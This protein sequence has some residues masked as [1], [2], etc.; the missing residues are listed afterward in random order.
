MLS[1]FLTASS[2][3]VGGR[4]IGLPCLPAGFGFGFVRLVIKRRTLVFIKTK[5]NQLINSE[6]IVYA[7]YIGGT[8]MKHSLTLTLTKGE[9]AFKDKEADALWKLLCEQDVLTV[10]PDSQ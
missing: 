8:Q 1:I 6:Q 2:N 10:N 3:V 5:N 9:L 4:M 7:E